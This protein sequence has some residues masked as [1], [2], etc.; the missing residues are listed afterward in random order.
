MSAVFAVDKGKVR[1][2]FAAASLSYDGVAGLQRQVGK[3]L[4]DSIDAQS[5]NGTVLDLGCGTGF[6]TGELLALSAGGQMIALDI[7]LPMLHRARSKLIG[8]TNVRYLCADA[9]RLP[10]QADCID[11]VCS[12][13]ALQ[14]CRNLP[15]VFSDMRRILKPGGRL[16]F[17]TFG[18]RTLQELKTAWAEVDQFNHVNEFY[19]E[20]ALRDFLEQAR[21]ADIQISSKVY[22]TTY[23]SVMALM[24]EL[25]QIGAHNVTVGRNKQMTTKAQMQ[26]MMNA[27]EKQG[28]DGEISATY[29]VITVSARV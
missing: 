13:L 6:L 26:A 14:W 28:A 15:V 7:A 27:Y 24:R 19:S 5:L 25:K 23:S 3:A 12:N 29:E 11:S 21:F 2:S 22:D 18:P 17:S 4:L 9:E 1:Q 20:Q 8:Q 10:L 16:Q